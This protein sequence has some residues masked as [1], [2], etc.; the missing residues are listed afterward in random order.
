MQ[1]IQLKPLTAEELSALDRLYRQTRSVRLRT[2]AHALLLI[3]EQGLSSAEA[4]ATVRMSPLS[5]VR[6]VKRYNAEGVEGLSDRPRPG[7]PCKASPQYRER[8]LELVRRRPRSLGLEFSLWTLRRLS[9]FMA[10]ETGERISHE[11]IRRYLKEGG[12]V[13][14]RP[15][16]TVTSPDPEYMVKKRRLK[17]SAITS[18]KARSSTMPTSSI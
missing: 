7:K 1:P 12:I 3:A 2:R 13:L 6:W 11:G 15:Q 4:A 17:R 16:H 8:L 18:A 10:E 14:S 5:V 9:D